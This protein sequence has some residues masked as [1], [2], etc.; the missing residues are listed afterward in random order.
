M[1]TD[2]QTDLESP[3]Q[4]EKESREKYRMHKIMQVEPF[5]E[6]SKSI[7]SWSG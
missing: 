3:E 2:W 1:V 6:Y 7:S 5:D 4:K